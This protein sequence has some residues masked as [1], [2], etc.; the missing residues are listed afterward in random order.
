MSMVRD[1]ASDR[2][3]ETGTQPH[4]ETISDEGTAGTG[5]PGRRRRI[6]LLLGPAT[7]LALLLLPAPAGMEAE[8]WRTAAVGVLMAIWWVSEAIPIPA[9]ALL[10][11][12]LFP[13]LGVAGITDA[14]TPYANPIIFLFLGGFMIAQAMQRWEL[15]RRIALLVILRVGT[16]PVR[17]VAGFMIAAAFLSMWVSNTATAVMMLPIGL[18]VI[19]LSLP[20][21]AG[22]PIDPGSSNFAVALMLGIAYACSIG[23]LGTLIGTP[24]NALLAGFMAESYGIQ[25][26]FGQWMLL[27]VPLV[28]IG[29]PATWLI[30]T[31]VAYPITLPGIPGGRET[32]SG[33]LRKMGAWTRGEKRVGMVFLLAAAAW[34]TRPLLEGWVP[35]ISDAGIAIGAALILFL[36]PVDLSRG[37]FALDWESAKGLPWDVLVLFGGGLSLAGA[38]TR[39]GLADWI[40]VELAILAILPTIAIIGGIAVVIIFL[41]E[42]TSNTATAAA[43]L[44]IL[45]SLA[46]GIGENPLLL[47]VPAALAASCA[48]MMPVAT[49][50]NAI[51]YGS[52]FVTI[53]QMVRA[54]LLLNFLFAVLLTLGGYLLILTVFGVEPGVVP[55]WAR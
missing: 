52:S 11:L 55:P 16:E 14:A 23:G 33:E 28:V 41:T 38:I 12:A 30:L 3:Y 7:F 27:G 43:F 31:R 20:R 51:V 19:H 2:V 25:I 18:S 32:I 13:L 22:E 1:H 29:L 54:G 50:P 34:M 8:A 21:R 5:P 10:P 37:H 9:T 53:P 48:F 35:G 6:G 40:G 24:P 46:V 36:L 4:P 15:H 42:L 45:A 44:P 39:T 17:L 49:P 47:A 26:G